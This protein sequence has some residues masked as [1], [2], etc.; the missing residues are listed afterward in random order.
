MRR[1]S[2]SVAA[3]LAVAAVAAGVEAAW[4]N[5]A[6][7]Q[8]LNLVRAWLVAWATLVPAA[9][10]IGG[11]AAL[12]AALLP[13]SSSAGLRRLAPAAPLAGFA[14]AVLLALT[15]HLLLGLLA[16]ELEP[17]AFAAVLALLFAA[18]A[19]TCAGA[20]L[21]LSRWPLAARGLGRLGPG[22]SMALG[23]VA[24]ALPIGYGVATGTP[25]GDGGFWGVFGVLRRQELDLRAPLML[26]CLLLGA[27][28]GSAVRQLQKV[29][30]AAAALAL[31]AVAL[32][33]TAAR[34]LDD[35]A[36]D[37]GIERGA[38][39]S[40]ST[41][42]L[43]RRL[44]D[45]DGDGVSPWF[46]GHD[47]NDA[48]DDVYPGAP[49]L[50]GNG[51]DEDCSGSDAPA[52][53]VDAALAPASTESNEPAGW[54]WPDDLNVIL[55]T[56]DTL[57]HDLG[58]MGY[59]RPISPNLDRL[60]ARSVVF[61]RAYAL[62]SYTGK[63]MGPMLI[64][65]YPSETHRGWWHFNRFGPEDTFLQERLQDAGIHT[66]GVQGHW[67]FTPQY[68]LGR[69]FDV[70]D[71]SAAPAKRQLEGDR[72]VL[73][74]DLSDAV[75]AQLSKPENAQDRFF[76]W[77]HYLDPHADYIRHP[78][79][80]FGSRARD[81]YD[82]EVAFTDQQIGRVLDFVAEAEFGPRTAIIVTSDHGEA[83]GENGMWRHGFE[84]WEVLV[85][86]PLIIH[87]PGV[88][89]RRHALRRS[90]IDLAPTVLDLFGLPQPAGDDRLS[91]QS[92][93]RDLAMPEGHVPEDRP[94]FIDMSA[95][96]YNEE[97]QALI[98]GD[99][100]L[101]MSA[102]RGALGLYDL[103][104]DPDEEVDLSRDAERLEA[105]RERFAAFQSRLRV[106][107]VKPR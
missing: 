98:E 86:V 106:V 42:K 65:R 87:V 64:G 77:V 22:A 78:E 57:R 17:L 23:L 96:P 83:F 1:L 8:P 69:G 31:G 70:L 41:L 61:E 40:R 93:A 27:L 81:A 103:E 85:R 12:I 18:L 97:R 10:A 20:A 95:G 26:L 49:D 33:A 46:G 88:E 104:R 48:R 101:I 2:G 94:I 45:S 38:A 34:L 43:M 73:S 32:V 39:L 47:C 55:I 50:P 53:V 89:P 71:M 5:A 4:A 67:Y 19:R 14:C 3:A 79:F 75:I 92:L 102:G 15:A 68:G 52:M 36:L 11:L 82:S 90:A 44:T 29:W 21:A 63:S 6:S 37:I 91:G 25:N 16:V 24:I 107:R 60:A 105:A 62:A 54:P 9:V 74:D 100:K 76:L 59:S 35:V 13:A 58:Y 72:T 80:D 84:V 7:T 99:L 56:V 30:W 28:A 66:I 51:I